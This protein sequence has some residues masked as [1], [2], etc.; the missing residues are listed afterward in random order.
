MSELSKK[1]KDQKAYVDWLES[2]EWNFFIT[3]TTRYQL[4]LK[5]ARRAIE[6]YHKFMSADTKQNCTI[7]WVAEPFEVKDGFHIHALMSVPD[8]FHERPY[9]DVIRENWQ[10]VTG[11]WGCVIN[12]NGMKV[13]KKANFIDVQRYDPKRNAG[14]YCLKYILKEG[15]DYDI[16]I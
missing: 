4:T 9:F 15:S 2:F 13:K 14:E 7:F 6:R 8:H 10:K 16:L 12:E 3:P 5:S 1:K 11:S